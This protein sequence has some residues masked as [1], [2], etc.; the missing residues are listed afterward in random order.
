MR[1]ANQERQN[2]SKNQKKE[3]R[4]ATMLLCIVI[5][6]LLCN[7]VP[8]VERFFEAFRGIRSRVQ[9]EIANLT[10]TIYSSVNFIIYMIFGGKFR[11][12]FF[13]LFFPCA[14]KFCST[15][16]R[17]RDSSEQINDDHHTSSLPLR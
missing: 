7:L 3:I 5:V 4:L 17:R 15:T 13:K 10:V 9:V 16:F 11:K 1:R 2:L 8:V 12:L 6:F 14:P